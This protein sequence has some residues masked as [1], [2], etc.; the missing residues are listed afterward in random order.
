M[1]EHSNASDGDN[2][3]STSPTKIGSISDIDAGT[4]H[5]HAPPKSGSPSKFKLPKS[6]VGQARKLLETLRKWSDDLME[7]VVDGEDDGYIVVVANDLIK[8]LEGRYRLLQA[9]MLKTNRVG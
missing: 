6:E 5:F 4:Q 9:E 8:E 2:G 3:I 1:D 7:F